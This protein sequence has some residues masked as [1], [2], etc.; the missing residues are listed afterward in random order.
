M[1]ESIEKLKEQVKSACLGLLK[2][3]IDSFLADEKSAKASAESDTKSSAGD[4]HETAR[5]M[6]QQEREMIGKRISEAEKQL[7]EL[8]KIIETDSSNTIQAGSLIYCT[9]GWMYL[10]ISLGSIMIGDQKVNIVSMD[11]PVGKLLKGKNIGDTI[12][13]NGKRIIIESVC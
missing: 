12:E 4:K 8:M 6:V 9:L 11:S 3:R 1:K 10:S 13:L 2:H 7:G 5:E